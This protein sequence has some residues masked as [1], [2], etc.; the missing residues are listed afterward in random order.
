M[1]R[2]GEEGNSAPDAEAE[3]NEPAVDEEAFDAAVEE[4]EEPL[5]RH[6]R[7]VVENVAARVRTLLVEVLFAIPGPPLR[8]RHSHAFAV[9]QPHILRVSLFVVS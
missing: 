6:V 3:V 5:L 7:P 1:K 8:L 4:V 9:G 2:G